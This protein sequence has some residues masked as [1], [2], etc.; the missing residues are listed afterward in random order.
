MNHVLITGAASG[1]G[2]QTAVRFGGIG[3]TVTL[4]D[5]RTDA[6][7]AAARVV[8]EAGAAGVVTITEDLQDADAPRRTVDAAWTRS[9]V[10][11]LVNSA[12][13]YPA[14]PFLDL[15]PSTWDA[16]QNINVRAPL[17][18]TV[19]LANAVIDAKSTASIVNISSGAA[20]RARPGAAAYSTSKSA[21]EMMTRASA[22]ELGPHGIRVNAV[23]PGF[24][25]VAS[26]VNPVTTEYAAA[27]SGNPLGRDGT[28]DDIARAVVWI[29]GSEAGWVTGTILRIDGGSS[30]G[31]HNLPL[32]W[33]TVDFTYPREEQDV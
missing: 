2:L 12:G 9:P 20:L 6:L 5:Y 3:A 10:D 28:P 22:L 15:T 31:A 7:A 18:A 21:L 30:T 26:D 29:S 4:V 19:A 33:T 27:V 8:R 16:V 13:I 23:A 25:A 1:I 32:S 17:L 24:I 14:L 11:I